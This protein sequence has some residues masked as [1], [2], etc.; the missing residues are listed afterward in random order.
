MTDEKK[1]RP[2]TLAEQKAALE[3]RKIELEQRLRD[4]K[5]REA[6]QAR[7]ERT[8]QLIALGLVFASMI[9]KGSLDKDK[10]RDLAKEHV[11]GREME[12][13]E[14]YLGKIEI[15]KRTDGA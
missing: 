2:R 5:A 14:A 8:G 11:Q 1:K 3:K 6:T 13:I 4:I 10:M 9:E 15:D 7:K 12:R